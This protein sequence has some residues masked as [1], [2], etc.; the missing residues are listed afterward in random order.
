M[1]GIEFIKVSIKKPEKQQPKVNKGGISMSLTAATIR[2]WFTV[3]G[4]GCAASV[5][6]W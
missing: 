5:G 2:T 3:V 1:R 6:D 4:L